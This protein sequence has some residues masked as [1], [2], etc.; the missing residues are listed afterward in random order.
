[1][2]A[3]WVLRLADSLPGP[4]PRVTVALG[5]EPTAN[6]RG[7]P[8]T[9]AA[10]AGAGAGGIAAGAL[11][12]RPLPRG[13]GSP[14]GHHPTDGSERAEPDQGGSCPGGTAGSPE[15]TA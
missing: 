12:H 6:G 8:R 10:T 14:V 7:F 5:K 2:S 11:G 13:H 9:A 1:M 4:G 15:A 3:P